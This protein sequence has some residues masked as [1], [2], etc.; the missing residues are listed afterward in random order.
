[1]YSGVLNVNALAFVAQTTDALP[2]RPALA[3]ANN[4]GERLCQELREKLAAQRIRDAATKIRRER[5]NVV[6][7]DR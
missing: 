1:M 7:V 6:G 4:S 3:Y 5:E 2:S